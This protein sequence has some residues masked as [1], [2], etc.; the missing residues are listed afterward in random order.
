MHAEAH[1]RSAIYDLLGPTFAPPDPRLAS[2]QSAQLF[3]QIGR[4]IKDRFADPALEPWRYR[5]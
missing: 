5:C 3:A 4:I 2:G 1:M